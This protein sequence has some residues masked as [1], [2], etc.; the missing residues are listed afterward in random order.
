MIK[1]L[2]NL[3]RS[4]EISCGTN[5]GKTFNRIVGGEDADKGKFKFIKLFTLFCNIFPYV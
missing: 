1:F 4:S 5:K 2:L 3:D